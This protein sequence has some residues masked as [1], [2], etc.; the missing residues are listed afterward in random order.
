VV[1]AAVVHGEVVEYR[2]FSIENVTFFTGY[3][4]LYIVIG[5]RAL[6]TKYTTGADNGISESGGG[7]G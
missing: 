4:A 6:L 5:H 1:A 7:G 3:R 2:A